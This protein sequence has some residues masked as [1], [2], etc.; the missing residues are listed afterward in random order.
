MPNRILDS[1]ADNTTMRFYVAQDADD[2]GEQLW[3][4]SGGQDGELALSL[5]LGESKSE[6]QEFV[7]T[8][9]H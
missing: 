1:F 6:R 3:R 8:T 5:A 7:P 4:I 9:T 2:I